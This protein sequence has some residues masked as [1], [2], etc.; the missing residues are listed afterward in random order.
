MASRA[1]ADKVDYKSPRYRPAHSNYAPSSKTGVPQ[2]GGNQRVIYSNLAREERFAWQKVGDHNPG[3][4]DYNPNHSNPMEQYAYV[5]YVRPYS[6]NEVYEATDGV[7][8]CTC[9]WK[10]HLTWSTS[11]CIPRKEKSCFYIKNCWSI[12]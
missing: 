4:A 11:M 8:L 2:T 7:P 5:D 10:F 12:P 1:N 9:R 3:P 6:N